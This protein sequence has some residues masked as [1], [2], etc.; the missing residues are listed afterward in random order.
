MAAL[1]WR[2]CLQFSPDPSIRPEW[3]KTY[4]ISIYGGPNSLD[5]NQIAR[6]DGSYDFVTLNMVL[7]FIPDAKA[8]FRELIR[9]LSV[10]GILQI[11]F[12]NAE[13]REASLDYESAQGDY[14]NGQG[15]FH[16]FGRDI[17]THFEL[18]RLGI[19]YVILSQVDTVTDLVT[20]FHFFGR[21]QCALTILSRTIDQVGTIMNE[22]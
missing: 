19:S 15:Y 11:G 6:T 10:D 1:A 3:F 2:R 17:E 12:A 5:L 21:D 13:S 16:L 7:E 20:Y 14:N 9:V 4:E 8:C 22:G 18:S